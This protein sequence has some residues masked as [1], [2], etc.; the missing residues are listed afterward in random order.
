MRGI[1]TRVVLEP[2]DDDASRTWT[3]ATAA[4]FEAAGWTV[5]H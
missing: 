1:P 2:A 3:A 4:A 5:S